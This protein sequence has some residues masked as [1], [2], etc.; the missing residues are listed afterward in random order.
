MDIFKE[1]LWYA[2]DSNPSDWVPLKLEQVNEILEA[3]AN[4]EFPEDLGELRFEEKKLKSPTAYRW[5]ILLV[6]APKT[7]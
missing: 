6:E 7:V 5:L 1:M 3:N 2:T 4:G